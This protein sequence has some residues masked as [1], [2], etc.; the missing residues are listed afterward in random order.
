M[1]L[2]VGPEEGRKITY[3]INKFK[4]NPLLL[5]QETHNTFI[6]IAHSHCVIRNKS[7]RSGR[8]GELGASEIATLY[9]QLG[10]RGCT[11]RRS[12]PPPF[13]TPFGPLSP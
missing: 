6:S 5:N 11:G 1:G 13:F 3:N 2:E 4:K 10:F 12:P 8:G 9:S 7:F